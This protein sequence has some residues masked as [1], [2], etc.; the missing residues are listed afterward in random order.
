VVVFDAAAAAHFGCYGYPKRTSPTV[1][2]IAAEPESVLFERAYANAPYTL[3]STGSLFTGLYPERH[4]VVERELKLGSEAVT[5]AERLRERGFTSAGFSMNAFASEKFGYHQGFDFFLKK[6]KFHLRVP[7]YLA[8]EPRRPL[9]LYLHYINPHAPYQ[10]KPRYRMRFADPDYRGPVDG[11]YASIARLDRLREIPPAD[12]RQLL[13]LYDADIAS[14]DAEFALLLDHF[15]RLGLYDQSLLV[16]TSDHGE[17][18]FQHGRRGHNT[19]VYDEML[20]IPLILKFPKGWRP[21]RRRIAEPVQTVD[22]TATLLDAAGLAAAGSELDG[23]SLL[24]LMF[25]GE[26]RP[27]ALLA[28]AEHGVQL[29]IRDRR[30]KLVVHDGPPGLELFDLETDPAEAR[31]LSSAQPVRTGLLLQNLRRLSATG[32]APAEANVVDEETRA[33]L[34]ALGYL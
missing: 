8:T 11:S 14:V 12:L 15:K 17:A 31:D 24:P 16:L 6:H 13:A 2:R 23:R 29:S 1:D 7:A 21:A 27:T 34:R 20:H 18:F 30:W 19:T 22:L 5:L 9:F 10:A 32:P 26:L 33:E 3:A 4:G 25:G 28:R